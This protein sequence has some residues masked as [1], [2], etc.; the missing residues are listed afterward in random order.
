MRNLASLLLLPFILLYGFGTNASD[1]EN[2]A[3]T[4]LIQDLERHL[5][6]P[7]FESEFYDRI[8]HFLLRNRD[9]PNPDEALLQ[10]RSLV[11]KRLPLSPHSAR[12]TES[13]LLNLYRT[14]AFEVPKESADDP[15]LHASVIESISA[16][17]MGDRSTA[18]LRRLQA[19]VRERFRAVESSLRAAML[20]S[21]CS[22]PFAPTA[23]PIESGMLGEW[24]QTRHPAVYG[25]LKAM[26][27]AYQSCEIETKSAIAADTADIEGIKITGKH[28]D[29][30][31]N[32]REIE[33]REK[34]LRSHPYLRDFHP[35]QAICHDVT[36][37]PLIYDYGGKPHVADENDVWMN[38]FLDAGS[39]TSVLGVDCSGYVYTALATAGL[40]LVKNQK[41]KAVGV[42]GVR[43]RQWMNPAT[44]GLSCFDNAVFT[45]DASLQPGDI[46][47]SNGHVLM[48]EGVGTDPFGIGTVT[49]EAQCAREQIAIDRFDFTFLHSGSAKGG[50]GLGR[51]E[52][53]DYLVAGGDMAEA[54]RDLA[55]TACLARLKKLRL[56]TKTTSAG[57]V[58]HLGGS[59]CTDQALRLT[60]ESCLYVCPAR[61]T[62]SP[63]SRIRGE[64]LRCAP[65][66]GALL[67]QT[68][69]GTR[70]CKR[71]PSPE[72]WRLSLQAA[73]FWA[74]SAE[75]M[76]SKASTATA[77]PI[78]TAARGIP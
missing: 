48:I 49:D 32:R 28:P 14:L 77:A 2:V 72:P 23:T 21:S 11:S 57:L 1:S 36:A 17:E 7:S 67:P 51:L 65:G 66:E 40:R 12:A 60:N 3:P 8:Y 78:S 38:F 76:S 25:A 55:S 75:G 10:F 15:S 30:V 45:A 54:M 62:R 73:A 31:G 4:S 58:R 64:I 37:S 9:L 22:E 52:G 6:C 41:L 34:L 42:Y 59:A 18:K 43:A 70:A 26:A 39:G 33:D 5:G 69:K 35:P 27:T 71:T 19:K 29:G 13:A 46:L 53:R 68:L 50:L 56:K 47:A 61:G 24:K 74:M 44:G 20:K 16:L 63:L